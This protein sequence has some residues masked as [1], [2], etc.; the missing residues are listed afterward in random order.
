MS[1]KLSKIGLT[2]VGLLIFGL[3]LAGCGG[4]NTSSTPSA[5]AESTLTAT[6]GPTGTGATA[7]GTSPAVAATTSSPTTAAGVTPDPTTAKAT[8]VSTGGGITL[9]A[10]FAVVDPAVR[11]WKS[12]AVYVSVFNP[13]DNK[14]G[15][16]AQGRAGQWYFEAISP[17]SFQHAF[18][19]VKVEAGNSPV[20]SKTTE[21]TLSKVRGQA[22][23]DHKLPPVTGLIDTDQLM[24][25]AQENGGKA[26]DRPVGTRLAQPAKDGDPLAF[27]VLFYNGSNVVR[28]RID[29]QSGKLVDN[30]KG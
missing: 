26:S 29:A 4:E 12:D 18:W 20:A 14:T 10:A 6:V 15:M 8:T 16:D 27:D 1:L 21:D 17:A 24:K 11:A 28:L 2:L 13:E 23:V 7:A 3:V 30:A 9:K 22:A 5:S 25:V 19:L